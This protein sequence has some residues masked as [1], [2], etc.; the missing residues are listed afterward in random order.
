MIAV[1]SDGLTDFLATTDVPSCSLYVA[2]IHWDLFDILTHSIKKKK[3][4]CVAETEKGEMSIYRLL[5]CCNLVYVYVLKWFIKVVI[6]TKTFIERGK[7]RHSKT[8]VK[9]FCFG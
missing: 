1:V 4:E 7:N 9:F 5:K 3:K 8:K 2:Q 6:Y